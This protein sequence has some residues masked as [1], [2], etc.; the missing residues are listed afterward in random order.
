MPSEQPIL[1]VGLNRIL[2]T[3]KA[4][5]N[6]FARIWNFPAFQSQLKPGSCSD[7]GNHWILWSWY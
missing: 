2:W 5:V 4:V 1:V 6:Y 7:N 3:A